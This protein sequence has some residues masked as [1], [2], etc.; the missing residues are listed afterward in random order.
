VQL[1][2][3]KGSLSCLFYAPLAL[4]LLLLVPG[5]FVSI[6][7]AQATTANSSQY[8]DH[9]FAALAAGDRVTL[10]S[11][12]ARTGGNL[13][14]GALEQVIQDVFL[15]LNVR[16]VLLDIG[17]QNFTAGSP[18]YHAWVN[19]WFTASDVMGISNVLY[20]GQLTS[21]GFGCPWVNSLISKDPTVATYYAN[22]TRADFVSLDN[23]EVARYVEIDLG[24]LYSYYGSH[25][26]WVGLG[27]GSSETNPYYPAGESMPD[28]GYSNLSIGSFVNSP[29]Y[30]TDVNGTGYLPNGELDALWSEYRDVQ[31]AIVLSSGLWMTSSPYQVYG[32]GSASSFVEMRFEVPSNTTTLQVQWY[33]NEVGSP[34]S[35]S[36]TVF[37]DKNGGLDASERLASLNASAQ[38]FTHSRGWQSGV[39]ANGNF[40]AGW[41]WVVFSSPSSNE[42]NYY[43]FYLKDYLINNATAYAAQPAIGPGFQT[44]LSTILWLKNQAGENLAIYPY[45]QIGIGAPAQAFTATHAY[46]FN[47]VFLFLSDRAYNPANATLTIT[48]TTDGNIV[49]TGLLSQTLSQG[50]E[51]WVPIALNGTVTTVPGQNYLITVDDPSVTWTTV[52]RYIITDPPQ[53]GFQNQTN[54]LL[55][56]LANV[57]WSQG[58]ENWGGMTSTGSDGVTTG[59]MNAVRFSPST[60]ETLKSVQIYMYTTQGTGQNFYTSGTLSVAIWGSDPDGSAPQGPLQQL[61]VPA[62]TVPQIGFLNATGFNTRV[63]EGKDYWIVFSANS[64]EKFTFGR[65]TSAFGFLVL[66]SNDGGVSWYNPSEGPTDYAFTVTLSKETLGT[67]VAGHIQTALTPSSIFAQPFVASSS[68]SVEGIY[69]GPLR[70]GPDLAISINP[71]GADGEPAV[72]PL[73]SGVFD[74]GNIT[75][76]YGPEFVQFSS[77]ANLQKGQEYWIELQPIGGDYQVTSLVYL[78]SAPSVPANSSAVVSN[79][80]GL[81]WKEISNSTALISEYLLETP[82]SQPP[83]YDTQVIFNELSANHD[84]SVSSGPLKGWNAYVQASE[85]STFSGVTQWLSNFTG[86]E[87]GFYTNAQANVVNQVNLKDIVVLPTANS[88]STCKGLLTEE[89]SA[90]ASGDSQFTYAPLSM[91]QQCSS[92]GIAAL[93][94]RL[95]YLPYLGKDF[96]LGT[97]SN[98][99]VVGDQP[100]LNLTSYLSNAFNT[101]YVNLSLDPS[102]KVGGSLSSFKAVLWLSSSNKTITSA[103]SSLLSQ[104]VRRGGELVT[105]DAALANLSAFTPVVSAGSSGAALLNASSFLETAL[106]HTVY[107]KDSFHETVSRTTLTAQSTNLVIS[108]GVVGVGKVVFIGFGNSSVTQTGGQSVV[109]S[110]ILSNAAGV[111]PP[112]WYGTN[113]GQASSAGE[114]SVEGTYGGPLLVWVYNPSNSPLAF[115]LNLNGSYY[116]IPSNWKTVEIPGLNV[117]VGSGSDVG[118]QTTVPPDTLVG[119]I[120][121]PRSEPLISYS[122][123]SV[124]TQ[125][126]YPNQ[127][128][129]SIAGKYNQSILV[130]ISANESANQVLL[131]DRTSLPQTTSVA[132]LYNTTSAWYFDGNTDSL[133]VKYQST[134]VDTLRFVFYTPPVSPPAVVPQQTVITIFGAAIA[135]EMVTL[136]FLAFR[137]RKQRPRIQN[138][139]K[140]L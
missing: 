46:S 17:W 18:P 86:R 44:G 38:S 126:A 81:A 29:Y 71:T 9:G 19:D 124:E 16:E 64:T 60:N 23:P 137:V 65:L 97:S 34:G 112:L 136:V 135:I 66:V 117:A 69:I 70:G 96:G 82:P 25:P 125:F 45:Q 79:N 54:A 27:T 139:D 58:L 63:T 57:A 87:F 55:F 102:L 59:Y 92:D 20:V 73:A 53:S 114:Y 56:E 121:V 101:T 6:V 109:I 52:M 85:L 110:N 115:S 28:V 83:Q 22:G 131:N 40:S 118:I 47:T 103:V 105:T 7:Q 5:P 61:T 78:K 15:P 93:A 133:F 134:G 116:G 33:G 98:V 30:G 68:A 62:T 127:A 12:E 41:Y 48:D 32:G 75:L 11:L 84:F 122:S 8:A 138:A 37:G 49:A 1:G 120:V 129:Y 123:G 100:T 107:A 111:P 104:Y 91:L 113:S 35:L 39:Q 108:A 119:L 130:M 13:S 74:A 140:S 51:N 128:L 90:I 43:T 132:R 99:L 67:F 95:N 72:S 10:S 31:P 77:V 89:E 88:T 42:N 14:V 2:I 26:S 94:Q 106:V 36:V 4:T 76:D 50:L 3:G 24:I 21:E 80:N